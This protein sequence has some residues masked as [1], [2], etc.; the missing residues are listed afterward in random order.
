MN[1][2]TASE[3]HEFTYVAR[4]KICSILFYSILFYSILFYS[5]LCWKC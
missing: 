4:L 2:A 5:I 3:I 1:E